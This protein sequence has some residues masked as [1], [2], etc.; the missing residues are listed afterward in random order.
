VDA[1]TLA[2]LLAMFVAALLLFAYVLPTRALPSAPADAIAELTSMTRRTH[3]AQ[4]TMQG[5][6][7]GV[8]IFVAVTAIGALAIAALF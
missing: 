8:L 7:M 3:S 2:V 6:M 1:R 5:L 4:S